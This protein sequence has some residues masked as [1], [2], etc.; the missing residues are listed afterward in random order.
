MVA[1]RAKLLIAP[2]QMACLSA[3]AHRYLG[4][5]TWLAKMNEFDTE[6]DGNYQLVA[7]QAREVVLSSFRRQVG[8]Q[9]QPSPLV[10]PV[11]SVPPLQIAN[12]VGRAEVLEQLRR[13]MTF[14]PDFQTRL[15]LWGLGELA[16][17]QIA[18]KY[19]YGISVFWVRATNRARF[20]DSYLEL[21]SNAGLQLLRDPADDNLKIVAEW[22]QSEDMADD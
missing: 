7:G 15:G 11:F 12:F 21:A 8:R 17:H 13:R 6:D 9:L 3:G 18:T 22:L 10:H 4:L 5:S 16:K 19:A 20:E 1:R 2:E 14:Q